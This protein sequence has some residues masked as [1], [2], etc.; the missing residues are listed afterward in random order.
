MLSSGRHEGNKWKRWKTCQF[1]K[2]NIDLQHVKGCIINFFFLQEADSADFW[3][4]WIGFSKSLSTLSQFVTT[5]RLSCVPELPALENFWYHS[6]A[7]F[8]SISAPCRLW[9]KLQNSTSLP[10]AWCCHGDYLRGEIKARSF[11]AEIE[12]VVHLIRIHRS[13]F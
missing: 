11:N 3:Y 8:K 9:S 13:Q 4:L 1:T 12:P 7:F 2:C 10:C 6:T 5:V